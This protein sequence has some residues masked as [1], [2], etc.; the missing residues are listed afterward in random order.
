[1]SVKA[2]KNKILNSLK[3]YSSFLKTVNEE[4]FLKTPKQGGW[5]YAEVYA[6]ILS[7]N[8]LSVV[9]VERC[10]NK[11]AEI[12]TRKPD[13]RVRLILFLGRFPPGKY[14]V[15]PAL[16][17]AVKKISKEQASNDLIKLV[18]KI[19]NIDKGFTKFNPDFKVKHPRLGYLDAKSWLRF[20]YVHSKH[21]QKQI[22]RIEKM[23]SS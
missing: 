5:S 9:A 3:F 7:A 13:W 16:E 2:D 6:H 17:P 4:T 8:F 10:L 22:G 23:L 20:I 15:P 21:H 11:T 18:Q 1:M 19:E 14:K 12:K